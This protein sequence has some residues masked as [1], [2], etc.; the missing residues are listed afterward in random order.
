MS[1]LTPIDVICQHS[2]DGTI[3]PLRI[4]LLDEDG[5]YQTFTVKGYR[6]VFHQGVNDIPGK[7]YVNDK[8]RVFDCNITVFGRSKT[9]TLYYEPSQTIWKIPI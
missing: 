2:K 6:E 7:A 8:V 1:E 3:I 5:E 9:I 4:R